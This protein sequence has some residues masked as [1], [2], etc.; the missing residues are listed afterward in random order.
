MLC[1][2]GLARLALTGALCSQQ[3]VRT[4]KEH[5][6][7]APTPPPTAIPNSLSSPQVPQFGGLGSS[8]QR[9]WVVVSHRYPNPK[10][11]CGVGLRAGSYEGGVNCLLACLQ[12]LCRDDQAPERRPV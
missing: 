8:W 2:L 10:V 1:V 12:T 11:G 7:P 4:C 9:R 6:C 5:N 3:L